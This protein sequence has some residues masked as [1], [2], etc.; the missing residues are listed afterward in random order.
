MAFVGGYTVF[1]KGHW[2]VPSFLFSYLMI[3]I[4]PMLFVGWKFLKKTKWVPSHEADLV[5]DLA[6]IEEYHRNYVEK[7]ETN[8]F[9]R[10]LDKMFG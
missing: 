9:N 1:L 4:F 6:E 3:F 7:P 8:P 2:D 5:S 10:F